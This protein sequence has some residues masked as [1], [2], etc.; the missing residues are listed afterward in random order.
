MGAARDPSAPSGLRTRLRM[1]SFFLQ[2]LRPCTPF[3]E[4]EH[5][6]LDNYL[7]ILTYCFFKRG[8]VSTLNKTRSLSGFYLRLK[9][10]FNTFSRTNIKAAQ[11]ESEIV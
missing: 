5:R 6:L 8:F 10:K 4:C 9:A 3:C 7:C 1:T 2:G 11:D